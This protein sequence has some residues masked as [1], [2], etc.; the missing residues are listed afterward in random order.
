MGK[1]CCEVPQE[2]R[3]CLHPEKA[4]V[5]VV[6]SANPQWDVDIVELVV[7][8]EIKELVRVIEIWRRVNCLGIAALVGNADAASEVRKARVERGA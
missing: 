8:H 2:S 3:L 7:V 4:L 1:K 5:V 6:G